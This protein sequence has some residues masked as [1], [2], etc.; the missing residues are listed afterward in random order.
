MS[1]VAKTFVAFAWSGI[2]LVLST[3]DPNG[4]LSLG[5]GLLGGL[6]CAWTHLAA[7]GRGLKALTMLLVGVALGAA[8]SRVG[9]AL[10][11]WMYRSE[12]EAAVRGDIHGAVLV[13]ADV[14]S[15]VKDRRDAAFVFI[16][17]P[18]HQGAGHA[19]TTEAP[20]SCVPVSLDWL[21]CPIS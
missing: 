4:V 8:G 2:W 15:S 13:G 16:Y 12:Y 9:S 19:R 6:A 10:Y 11:F 3:I 5:W 17:D 7:G 21:H 1:G 20:G 14:I 18:D